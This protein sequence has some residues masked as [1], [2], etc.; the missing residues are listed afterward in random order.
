MAASL[1]AKLEDVEK[2]YKELEETVTEVE[3]E[4]TI[5]VNQIGE[6]KTGEGKGE[7]MDSAVEVNET[8]QPIGATKGLSEADSTGYA[9]AKASEGFEQ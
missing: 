7:I 3:N 5:V 2:N 1:E 9:A 6:C 8:D 4:L